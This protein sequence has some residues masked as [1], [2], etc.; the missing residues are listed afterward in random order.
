MYI[1]TFTFGNICIYIL[2]NFKK[3]CLRIVLRLVA[4]FLLTWLCIVHEH[5]MRGINHNCCFMKS[6][7][8]RIWDTEEQQI[9]NSYLQAELILTAILADKRFNIIMWNVVKSKNGRKY[10]LKQLFSVGTLSLRS[11]GQLA[12]VI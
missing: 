5:P 6:F 12:K 4:L 7:H 2:H 11:G 1:F 8:H 3:F 9:L 10:Q